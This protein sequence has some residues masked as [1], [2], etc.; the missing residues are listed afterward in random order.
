MKDL[1]LKHFSERTASI[2]D[3]GIS[4][5]LLDNFDAEVVKADRFHEAV[6]AEDG[7]GFPLELPDVRGEPD[8]YGEVHVFADFLQRGEHAIGAGHAVVLLSGNAVPNDTSVLIN[9]A[10]HTKHKI[11]LKNQKCYNSFRTTE[12]TFYGSAFMVYSN[13]DTMMK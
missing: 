4:P 7:D 5:S 10:T 13:M 8:R 11:L 12:I 9:C 1:P 2:T 6:F 3:G